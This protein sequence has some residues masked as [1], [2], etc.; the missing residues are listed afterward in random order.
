MDALAWIAIGISIVL[1]L[2]PPSVDPAIRFKEW[3]ERRRE[4]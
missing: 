1:V 2:L 4:K 3:V